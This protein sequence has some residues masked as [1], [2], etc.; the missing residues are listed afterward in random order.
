MT[1][2]AIGLVLGVALGRAYGWMKYHY[3]ESQ[4]MIRL[5][6]ARLRSE[7]ARYEV[8]EEKSRAEIDRSLNRRMRW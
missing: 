1:L 5:K 3:P 8:E 6:Q 7:R 2:F 4:E